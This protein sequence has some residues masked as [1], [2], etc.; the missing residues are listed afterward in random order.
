MALDARATFST[1]V[2]G[3]PVAASRTTRLDRLRLDA[4][5]SAAPG[6][7]TWVKL[8]PANTLPCAAAI[9]Q[10]VPLVCQVGR[11]SAVKWSVGAKAAAGE[12]RTKEMAIA[13]AVPAANSLRMSPPR[14]MCWT[15]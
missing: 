12:T 6:G 4:A 9:P 13:A 15:V 14:A 1:H 7:R 11:L 8:P 10:T 5:P 3:L 2:V